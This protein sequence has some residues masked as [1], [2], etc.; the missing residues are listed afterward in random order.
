MTAVGSK[1]ITTNAN[2]GS[3]QCIDIKPITFDELWDNYVTGKPYVDPKTGEVPPGYDNQCA[4][5]MSMTLHHVGIDMKSFRG[6]HRILMEGKKTSTMAAELATW[7]DMKPFCGISHSVN[8]TGD[9]WE[10]EVDD[11]TGIIFF[12]NYWHRPGEIKPS[13]SHIDLWNGGRL[14]VS[15]FWDAFATWGRYFG[16]SQADM[17]WFDERAQWSDLGKS[18]RILFWEIE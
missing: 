7:L 10:S 9:D 16:K 17:T 4:I 11:K 2:E 6:A 15:S 3:L 12:E 1:K 18:T 5:R 13:G 8:I 14:T